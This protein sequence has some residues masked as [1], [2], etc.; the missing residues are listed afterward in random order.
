MPFSS[1]SSTV[2]K[3]ERLKCIVEDIP[4]QKNT[5]TNIRDDDP[6]MLMFSEHFHRFIRKHLKKM[7]RKQFKSGIPKKATVQ[8]REKQKKTHK[9]VCICKFHKYK[10]LKLNYF[11][12]N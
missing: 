7:R 10:L 6:A 3:E 5:E 4:Q 12:S 1:Y 9:K 2:P 8:T 11:F